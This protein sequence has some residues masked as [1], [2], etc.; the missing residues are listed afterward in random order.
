MRRTIIKWPILEACER[1]RLISDPTQ[2]HPVHRRHSNALNA[3][4]EAKMPIL[5]RTFK[6]WR[7]SRG[8]GLFQFINLS[9]VNAMRMTE[10][11]ERV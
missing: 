7:S 8:F 4:Q 5:F 3:R 2:E 1:E 9:S 6:V 11:E 10:R